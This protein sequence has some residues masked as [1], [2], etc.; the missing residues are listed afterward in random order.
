MAASPNE[1]P[2]A[3]R[4]APARPSLA[5]NVLSN[6]TTLVVSV[7]A[8]FITTPVVVHAL[9]TERY[10]VW[11]FLNGLLVYSDLL[12]LG[13]GA[14]IIKHVA[15][16]LARDDQPGVNRTTSVVL[17]IYAGLGTICFAGFAAVSVIVPDLFA[18]PLTGELADSARQVCLLLGVQLFFTFIGAGY[19][20]NVL[21]HDRF[22]MLNALRVTAVVGRSA[23]ILFWLNGSDPLLVLGRIT[24][25]TAALEAVGAALLARHV[26]PALRVRPVRPTVSELKA[27]Y[28]FGVPSF[29]LLLATTLIA[30]TDTTVIGITLGAASV[31]VYALPLQLVEYIRVCASGASGTLLPRLTVMVEQGDA[32]GVRVAYI[33]SARAVM[34]LSAFMAAHI[35]A[36]GP[37]F[38][39]LWVGT[40]FGSHVEWVI[41]CLA[42]AAL[43]HVLSAVVPSG[44]YQATGLLRTPATVLL[45]EAL[46]NLILSIVLAPRLGILGVALGTLL[47]A[48]A[49]SCFV[50]PPFLWKHLR[51]SA[52]IAIRGIVP[53]LVLFVLT[54][55]A[56]ALIGPLVGGAS[57]SALAGRVVLTLPAG[58]AVFA[59]LFPAD[60]REWFYGIARRIHF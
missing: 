13:L 34:C 10:G 33:R 52:A 37:A 54:L 23:A 4:P 16:C 41:V 2:S 5:I 22:D 25:T 30:Y 50:L 46:A 47:P 36:M 9:R 20:G 55:T 21:G 27:L 53:A 31:A 28:S 29:V 19:S 35:I 49:V 11:S 18:V 12:Y 60:D 14:A 7:L 42:S 48:A 3:C 43:L 1:L 8:T 45:L 57:Y 58:L 40:E 56:Q 51:I 15:A 39:T 26:G 17:T 59:L 24:A 44:F 6:W 32:L 38:L